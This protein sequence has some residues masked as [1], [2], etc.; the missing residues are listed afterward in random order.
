MSN[1]L[2]GRAARELVRRNPYQDKEL[3]ATQE[4]DIQQQDQENLAEV[5]EEML[6]LR[7]IA[8]A[9]EGARAN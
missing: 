4:Q 2:A 8:R 5:N 7:G 9:A 3:A 6:T 1:V